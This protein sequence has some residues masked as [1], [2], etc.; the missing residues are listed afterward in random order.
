MWIY[1][2]GTLAEYQQIIDVARQVSEKR[3]VPLRIAHYT[4]SLMGYTGEMELARK[5]ILVMA[6]VTDIAPL[7]LEQV[8]KHWIEMKQRPILVV[9]MDRKAQKKHKDALERVLLQAAAL[10]EKRK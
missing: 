5:G 7:V 1:E 9:V 8:L 3:D 2:Q 10:A 6:N 4:L